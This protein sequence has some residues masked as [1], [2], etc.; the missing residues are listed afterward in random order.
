MIETKPI[1]LRIRNEQDGE[2]QIQTYHGKWTKKG[3]VTY[4]QYLEIQPDHEEVST[5][6][7]W[8]GTEMK[9]IRF[10]AVQSKLCFVLHQ[11]RSGFLELENQQLALRTYTTD[12]T[13]QIKQHKAFLSWTYTLMLQQDHEVNMNIQI[14]IEEE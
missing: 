2:Q 12:L 6:I 8:D 9:V 11:E 4:I 14:K 5:T 3:K 7:R 1:K 13:V 10:G